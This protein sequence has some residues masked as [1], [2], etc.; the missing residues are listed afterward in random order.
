MDKLAPFVIGNEKYSTLD[1]TELLVK[2][3]GIW[4]GVRLCG[5]HQKRRNM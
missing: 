3:V 2:C 1:Q 4:G 5:E